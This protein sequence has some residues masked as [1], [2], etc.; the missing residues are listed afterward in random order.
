MKLYH[1]PVAALWWLKRLPY[2]LFIVREST[3]LFVGLYCILLLFF[4][5][6]LG[7]GERA[8]QAMLA[9]LRSAPLVTLHVIV[10]LFALYHSV[11]WFHLAPKAIVIPRGEE[12]VPESL[13]AGASYAAWVALSAI[14]YWIIARA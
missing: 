10:L 11:T 7:Q 8:Y 12:Q 5:Y 4:L 6:T 3:A 9:F 2:V 14:L 13:I 1:R